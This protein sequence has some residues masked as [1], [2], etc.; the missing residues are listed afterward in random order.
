[1]PSVLTPSR[2]SETDGYV[3]SFEAAWGEGGPVDVAGFLPPAKHPRFHELATEL[4]R[5]DVELRHGNGCPR[6]L[7]EYRRAFPQVLSAPDSWRQL[8]FEEYRQK[9]EN[10]LAATPEEYAAAYGLDTGDWPRPTASGRLP[11]PAECDTTD[12]PPP[13]LVADPDLG[14]RAASL[15]YRRMQADGGDVNTLN[16]QP[17]AGGDYADAAELI[18]TIHRNNPTLARRLTDAA[19]NMPEAGAY[20]A[21]F[22][23]LEELGRGAF[24]RVFLARQ[25][26]LAGRAVALK[27]AADFPGE[28]QV[29]AR[30]QHTNI[31][32]VYSI[33]R[34]AGLQGLCMPYF[35]RTTLADVV[36]G[37]RPGTDLPASGRHIVSTVNVRRTRSASSLASA[38][39]RLPL[40]DADAAALS[41]RSPAAADGVLLERIGQ[42]TYTQAVLW[43][44]ARLAEGL[45][46][47]H[48][49]G[50]IHRDLKPANVLVTDDGQPMLLDFNLSDDARLPLTPSAARIGGTLPYMSPEQLAS[51][52]GGG[53]AIDGRSDVYSLG[54]ILFELL[55]GRRLRPMQGGSVRKVLAR[56]A[57]DSRRPLPALRS[58][59]PAVSPATQSIIARCLAPDPADRYADAQHLAED[60]D[61]QLSDRP[62][63]YAPEPSLRE[64]AGK[65]LRRHPRLASTST[66]IAVAGVVVVGGAVAGAGLYRRNERL[67]AA[68]SLRRVDQARLVQTALV[69]DPDAGAAGRV[70]DLARQ[71]LAPLGLPDA[72]GWADSGRVTALPDGERAKLRRSVAE[73]LQSWADA[74]VRRAELAS[75]ADRAAALAL[76]WSLNERAVGGLGGA[77]AG[78][79]LIAQRA[80]IAGLAGR[81][82]ADELRRQSSGLRPVSAGDHFERGRALYKRHE[83]RRAIPLFEK[84]TEL[85]PQHFWAWHF[86]G[87]CHLELL[88]YQEAVACYSACQSL[89]PDPA[90]A[91][92]PFY[93]RAVVHL[94]QGRLDAAEADVEQAAAALD[95][96]PES[97]RADEGPRPYLLKAE[98]LRRRSDLVGA[99]RALDSA[100]A[101]GSRRA[102]VYAAR[103]QVRVL[104]GDVAGAQRDRDELL[105]HEPSGEADWV[106][107]GL[108]RADADPAG[109][110]ADFDQALA[111]NPRFAMAL[112]NKAAVLAE[113]GRADESL[114]VLNR[115]VELYPG[116]TKARIGRA[117][118]LARIGR[119]A[120]A[121]DDVRESLAR[122]RGPETLYQS[123]N[124]YALTSRQTAADADRVVPLLA[125]ALWNGFGLDVFDSDS[126][127]EPVRGRDDV[128]RLIA[129]VRELQAGT[130]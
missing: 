65:W 99:E 57:E 66:A 125:A 54:L 37:L 33:H 42:Y 100:L 72:A 52:G 23:L 13:T 110:L 53:A 104:A 90:V 128:R 15:A 59:N 44:G 62:L 122:D 82:D 94:R 43:M 29:L 107:R 27:I 49:R 79:G 46:H 47:A 48:D 14:L 31:V 21:G 118:L 64:R 77:A 26:E 58:M 96:L 111:V 39:G 88:H 10:G 2:L 11:R 12:E 92:Y 7:L 55:S 95:T 112:Q 38:S 60:I 103:S 116:Y 1:M 71:A 40:V 114:A 80:R 16:P 51:F 35:G 98:I 91:Y 105:R 85:E 109:A 34:A 68:A 70:A 17:E 75:G 129:V 115:L 18:L 45:A 74:E 61:R 130:P 73:V 127:M 30:L 117:V 108:A 25:D 5:V 101:F 97:I 123:A 121:H 120:D 56:L 3:R 69:N 4:L 102:Q 83:Y 124:V 36:Q 24:G 41:G 119:R 106:H 9:V 8:V 113:I 93:H 126:D 50:I 6:D 32:P 22:R 81:A 89:T 87:S 67:E 84:A 28:S 19:V 20:F 63:R 86:L 78:E 76:A